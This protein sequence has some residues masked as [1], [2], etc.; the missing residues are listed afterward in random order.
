VCDEFE[1]KKEGKKDRKSYRHT[2][3]TVFVLAL[4]V[5]SGLFKLH[6]SLRNY[7]WL[8]ISSKIQPFFAKV[9]S[10]LGVLISDQF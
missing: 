6:L 4:E 2:Y 1:R 9:R 7:C 5:I 10:F 3:F 8:D